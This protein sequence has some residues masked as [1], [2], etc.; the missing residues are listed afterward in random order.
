MTGIATDRELPG[1]SPSADRFQVRR[2]GRRAA[3]R[4]T[5][6][7]PGRACDGL[8]PYDSSMASADS[9]ISTDTSRIDI[10]VVHQYLSTSYW[11]EG[12]SR[13][14]VERSIQNSFCFGVYH[15]DRQI[16][17][18]RVV[19]DFA[20]FAYFADIFVI[21]EFQGRGIGKALVHAMLEHPLIRGLQVILLRT[22]DAHG[23]YE[24]FGFGGCRDLR[25]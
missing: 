5:G 24:Q 16:G 20:V 19:A 12:R 9:G 15:S 10:A 13:T 6:K 3:L 14:V 21:P 1:R 4:V 17:F 25:R 7:Q 2:C 23:L 18:G 8:P 22:R 11:G